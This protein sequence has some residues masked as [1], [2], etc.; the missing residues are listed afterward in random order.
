M[1]VNLLLCPAPPASAGGF[2]VLLFVEFINVL[3]LA[4]ATLGC[5]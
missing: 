3:N 1:G 2:T 5:L 4:P